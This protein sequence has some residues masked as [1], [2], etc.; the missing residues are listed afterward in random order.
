MELD[1]GGLEGR[2][3]G[4][5]PMG[6]PSLPKLPEV[7]STCVPPT[8][9]DFQADHRDVKRRPLGHVSHETDTYFEDALHTSQSVH[10][11]WRVRAA[12]HRCQHGVSGH[13][14]DRQLRTLLE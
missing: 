3:A 12:E 1:S 9:D 13:K 5:L 14:G 11:R 8:Y 7:E 6:G 10:G 2:K 4:E